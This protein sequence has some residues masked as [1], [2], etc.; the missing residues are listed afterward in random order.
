MTIG[1]FMRRLNTITLT[2]TTIITSILMTGQAMSPIRIIIAMSPC[3]TSIRT[4]RICITDTAMKML[5]S[6]THI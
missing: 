1:T 6:D 3:V 4:I 5:L 2:P